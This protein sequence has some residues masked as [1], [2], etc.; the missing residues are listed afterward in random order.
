MFEMAQA[1]LAP[2]SVQTVLWET[3][4]AKLKSHYAPMPSR[5]ARCHTFHHRNQAEGENINQYVAA[6]RAA[7]LYCDFDNLED[8][9]LDQLICGLRDICIQCHLLAKTELTRRSALDEEPRTC[10]IC[11]QLRFKKQS[12]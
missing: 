2:L 6:L 12:P 7:L 3:L 4:L 5:I 8:I 10:P 11:L 9:L 1:L